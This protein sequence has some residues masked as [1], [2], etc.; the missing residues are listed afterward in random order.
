[1]PRA[2]PPLALM[3]LIWF[4][5]AQPDLSS[6]LDSDLDLV[7]RKLAHMAVFGTLLLLWWRA[8][9]PRWAV[10]L[11]LAYAGVD[12]WHQTTVEGRHGAVSDVAIDAL[13][14]GVAALVATTLLGFGPTASRARSR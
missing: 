6:G 14:M 4:L 1:M 2:L 3:G 5:S 7:L 12:E 11:T 8:L 10:A 13:G 9:G